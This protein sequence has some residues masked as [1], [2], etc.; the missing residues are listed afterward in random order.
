[1]GLA[2]M[3]TLVNFISHS[4][5]VG[6]TAGAAILIMTKQAEN[7]PRSGT[8]RRGNTSTKPCT[9]CGTTGPNCTRWCRWWPSITLGTGIVVKRLR[10]KW[11]AMLAALIVGSLSGVVLN[12]LLHG[13][14]DR[15]PHGGGTATPAAA[16][17][18]AHILGVGIF[19]DLAPVALAMT[20]FALTEAVSIARSI[21]MRSGQPIEGNQEFIGQGLSNLA[22]SFFSAYVATGSFNRSG[23]NYDAGARTPLAA[24]FAGLL[25]V[26]VVLAV[27]AAHGLPASRRHG[28]PAVPGGLAPDRL[29]PHPQHHPRRS[30][31]NPGH[32]GDLFRHP[33][34]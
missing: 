11:P 31:G 17:V 29:P 12:L 8:A 16:P 6:F 20:L 25:L 2:K 30:Q 21:S 24:V 14:H 18:H 34:P 9:T 33:V 27:R 4:V 26:V 7:F 15:H 13:N 1:M 3:G 22:G 10:P 28:R 32:G 19:R 5:I 23:A